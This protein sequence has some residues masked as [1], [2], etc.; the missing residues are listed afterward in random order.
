MSKF[1]GVAIKQV[2]E[3]LV[4]KV[5]ANETIQH[6][7]EVQNPRLEVRHGVACVHALQYLHFID[8]QLS[9]ASD[10]VFKFLWSCVMY[11]QVETVYLLFLYSSLQSKVFYGPFNQSCILIS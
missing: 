11:G 7:S 9:V 1:E 5:G 6:R 8:F 4:A 3:Y 10:D 2:I